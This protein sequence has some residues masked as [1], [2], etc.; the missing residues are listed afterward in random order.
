MAVQSPDRTPFSVFEGSRSLLVTAGGY[1]AGASVVLTKKAASFSD[2]A[3]MNYYSATFWFPEEMGEVIVS[4]S[5]S[6][7]RGGTY[8]TSA[9]VPTG[10][11]ADGV[12]RPF[13]K[14]AF[15]CRTDA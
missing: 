14:R 8:S 9:P 5:L 2:A 6:A 10:R 12:F 13:R 1:T 7:R 4:L 3:D 15:G 11:M